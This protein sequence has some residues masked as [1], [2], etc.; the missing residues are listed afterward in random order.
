VDAS[1]D[2]VALLARRLDHSF[3]QPSL[4]HQALSH[5]SWCGEQNGAPSNERLEFLGDA[6]LGLVVA[7]RVY[8]HY[9]DL[10]EGQ[11]AKIRSA[12]VNARVLAEV[13]IELGVGEVLLLGRGEET[14]GGRGKAS[15]LAD[16][17]EALIGAVYLDA[18]WD[19]ASRLV[20]RLV[21]DRIAR[22]ALEPDGFDH[23]SQLQELAARRSDGPPRY[24]VVGSGPDHDRHYVAQV[25]LGDALWGTGTGSS[26]KDAQ[27]R[28]ARDA[29]DVLT[30]PERAD[31]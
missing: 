30:H 4:L 31:A 26:K 14:S 6:V 24:V 16:A 11:L 3:D 23:K 25:Y 9:P 12:V 8:R 7:D 19:P 17:L 29:F 18:G 21:G 22:A 27:Q 10:A 20:L 1:P 5:R 28:A 2:R 13:A 15:I